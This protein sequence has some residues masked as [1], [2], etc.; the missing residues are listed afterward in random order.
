M[1]TT[2]ASLVAMIS[3]ATELPLT[4]LRATQGLSPSSDEESSKGPHPLEIPFDEAAKSE[5]A[6]EPEKAV[7]SEEPVVETKPAKEH[8]PVQT[9]NSPADALAQ[10]QAGALPISALP[11]SKERVEEIVREIA[12]KMIEEVVWEVIP[13]LSEQF[14]K[15][16]I[17]AKI[18]TALGKQD[19]T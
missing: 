12:T 7:E 10:E 17:I 1:K 16:E 4:Q 2:T 14:I 6:S 5:K 19:K 8:R 11:I 3:T 15:T 18:K 9:E 13:E